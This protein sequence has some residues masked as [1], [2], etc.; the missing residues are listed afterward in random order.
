MGNVSFLAAHKAEQELFL[1]KTPCDVVETLELTITTTKREE[2]FRSRLNER[3]V[4]TFKCF[5]TNWVFSP[6]DPTN[7]K[8]R[9]TL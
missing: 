1:I 4:M 7:V 9:L 5:D 8:S 2:K 6:Q 3:T